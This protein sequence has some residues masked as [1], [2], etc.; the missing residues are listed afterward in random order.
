MDEIHSTKHMDM[1][2]LEFIECL[3]R[4]AD[5]AIYNNFADFPAENDKNNLS[6]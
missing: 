4:I 6:S 1:L 3:A 5:K 2:Y